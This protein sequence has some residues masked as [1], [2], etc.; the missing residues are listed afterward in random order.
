[1]LSH[2]IEMLQSPESYVAVWRDG[3]LFILPVS[4]ASAAVK[5]SG[6]APC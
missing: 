6:C 4:E 2:L 3:E 1:M 5:A